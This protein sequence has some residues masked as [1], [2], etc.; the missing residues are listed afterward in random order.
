MWRLQ[1]PLLPLRAPAVLDRDL[2]QTLWRSDCERRLEMLAAARES[3]LSEREG[4][5]A[6]VERL[7]TQ[8]PLTPAAATSG[9]VSG[10][11]VRSA[12]AE[13]ELAAF[14]AAAQRF[15]RVQSLL[16]TVDAL[17]TRARA[18]GTRA[19]RRVGSAPRDPARGVPDRRSPQLRRPACRRPRRPAGAQ[20]QTRGRR[21][22]AAPTRGSMAASSTP[23]RGAARRSS[24]GCIAAAV[25][26]EARMFRRGLIPRKCVVAKLQRSAT[27]RASRVRCARVSTA[28]RSS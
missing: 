13:S 28:T 9:N 12:E 11:P 14:K 16:A 1:S 2:L 7:R 25:K 24:N 17:D 5:S 27:A 15:V 18:G 19:G 26:A 21:D 8:P 10:T 6:E 4:I 22:S 20:R 3:A 23:R